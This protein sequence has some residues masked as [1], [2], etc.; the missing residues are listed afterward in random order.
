M[1]YISKIIF[2]NIFGNVVYMGKQVVGNLNKNIWKFHSLIVNYKVLSNRP[3]NKKFLSK[4][5]Y[6]EKKNIRGFFFSE[7]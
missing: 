4:N 1:S 6:E 3:K 5:R 7:R 2:N